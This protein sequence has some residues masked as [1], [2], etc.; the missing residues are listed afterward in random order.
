MSNTKDNNFIIRV[1]DFL[2]G[3]TL[4]DT[5]EF[6]DKYTTK[7]Q[8][9]DTGINCIIHIQAWDDTTVLLDITDIS[10]S[11]CLTC[12]ICGE[13]YT[14]SQH[15]ERIFLKC[16]TDYDS[17]QLDADEISFSSKHGRID[18][19]NIFV[20]EISLQQNIQQKCSTCVKKINKEIPSKTWETHNI[21]RK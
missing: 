7:I 9:L 11:L 8:V 5:I 16:Y 19:E 10:Y 6:K 18:L 12:D 20:Q 21:I 13:K 3:K 1:Q 2:A 15:I 17:P 14:S 4:Q